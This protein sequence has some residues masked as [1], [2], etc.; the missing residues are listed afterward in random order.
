MMSVPVMSDGIRS[1]VNWMRLNFRSSTCASVCDEQRLGQ[2]RHAD[3]DAVAADEERE[4]HLL[5]HVVLPD[6]QLAQLAEHAVAAFLQ[7]VGESDVVGGFQRRESFRL[8]CHVLFPPR[9]RGWAGTPPVYRARL[10]R[11]LGAAAAAPPLGAG[12]SGLGSAAFGRWAPA[13]ASRRLGSAAP[14]AP[15]EG[16]GCPLGL[17]LPARRCNLQRRRSRRGA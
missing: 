12:P 4:Q 11:A 16:Q 10:W 15:L 8:G 7:P 1:G 13:G 2:P 17:R 5:E 9:V 14:A 6:D 3:Q